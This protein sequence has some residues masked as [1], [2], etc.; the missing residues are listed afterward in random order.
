MQGTDRQ[1]AQLFSYIS[2]E[3]LVPKDHPLRLIRQL[4]NAALDRLSPDF[5]TLYSAVGRPSIPPEHLLRALLLQAFF[6]VRSER[7]LME[8]LT[9]N[10]LFGW[11][12]GLSMDAPV[13]DVT[14]FTKNRDRLLKGE[15]AQ[16]FLAALLSDPR[17]RPLLSDEHFSIDGTLIEAWASMKSFRPKD[18]SGEPPDAG[19]NGECDFHGEKRSN[20]THASTTDPDARLYKKA[21]GQAAK[22]CHMGHVLMENRNGLVVEA[23]TTPAT[24]TAEREAAAAML[25][26]HAGGQRIT[27]GADRAYDTADFVAQMRRQGVTPHVTQNNTNRRSAIDG[28]TTRHP[29]YA[30]SLRIRKRIEAVFGW[31]KTVGGQ[32]KTRFCGTARV[33]WMFTLAAAA[34]NLV[35][36]P[37]LL[38]VAA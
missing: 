18:G 11:F 34:Y 12:T 33:G 8:Q 16:A 5:R 22:L 27:V 25:A 3:A 17:V 35:R 1:T 24:G 7:Q 15:I 36:L 10:M 23:S 26:Q 29:G 31:M 21:A 37:K 4:A 9:Y 30:V 13:W 20:G 28:R 32:R 19:R 14:V 2:P 38:D 6:S